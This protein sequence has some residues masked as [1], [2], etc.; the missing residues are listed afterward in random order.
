MARH[1]TASGG[2]EASAEGGGG[3]CANSLARLVARLATG[4]PRQLLSSAR[5]KTYLFRVSR[6]EEE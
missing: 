5:S 1:A 3:V 4:A 2:I 6:G